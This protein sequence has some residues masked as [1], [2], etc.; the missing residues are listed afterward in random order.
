MLHHRVNKTRNKYMLFSLDDQ[1]NTKSSNMSFF[2]KEKE[3]VFDNKMT[4]KPNKNTDKLNK[5]HNKMNNL[6]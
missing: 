1:R 5:H 4:F 2:F 3:K 6:E